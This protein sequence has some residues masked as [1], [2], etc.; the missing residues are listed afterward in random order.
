LERLIL[1]KKVEL[2]YD[3]LRRDRRGRAIAHVF[4]PQGLG[5]EAV[6]VQALYSKAVWHA[7]IPM[8]TIAAR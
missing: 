8:P 3:G 2:R 4:V 1:G 6:W 7:F 5:K